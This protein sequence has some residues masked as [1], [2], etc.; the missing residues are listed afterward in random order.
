MRD[1]IY[2]LNHYVSLLKNCYDSVDTLQFPNVKHLPLMLYLER[3]FGIF[4]CEALSCGATKQ[5]NLKATLINIQ[6][7]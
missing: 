6:Y 3:G 2:Q 7:I 1:R 5:A 4:A